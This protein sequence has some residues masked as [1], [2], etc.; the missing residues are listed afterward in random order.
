MHSHTADTRVNGLFWN[1]DENIKNI[2][3]C[4]KKECGKT[5]ALGHQ[6]EKTAI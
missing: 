1:L 2:I 6:E 5:R 4:L 3:Q